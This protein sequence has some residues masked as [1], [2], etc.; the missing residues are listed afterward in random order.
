MCQ[1]LDEAPVVVVS[2]DASAERAVAPVGAG[3]VK[4]EDVE[5]SYSG[6]SDSEASAPINEAIEA[7]YAEFSE[8]TKVAE[9]D[10]VVSILEA[11][12]VNE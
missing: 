10:E 2:P 11:A 6:D 12:I 3:M 9:D 5:I 8:D 7:V 1:M 4:M